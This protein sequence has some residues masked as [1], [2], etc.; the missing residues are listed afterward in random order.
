MSRL[1]RLLLIAALGAATGCSAFRLP[2]E[3]DPDRSR[4]AYQIM[5][6]VRMRDSGKVVAGAQVTVNGA[7]EVS[8]SGTTDATGRFLF[9]VSDIGGKKP[10]RAGLEKGP[11]GLVV[12]SARSGAS[13]APDTKVLLPASGPVLLSLGPCK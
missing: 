6:E 12:L 11:A 1:Y 3:E 8:G 5:G 10:D 7:G 4:H 2:A 9:V 13:C